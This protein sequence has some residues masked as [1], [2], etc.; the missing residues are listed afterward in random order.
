[1]KMGDFQQHKSRWDEE[2]KP[3]IK[4]IGFQARSPSLWGKAKVYVVDWLISAG[5]EIPD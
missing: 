3:D 1:M 2:A 4:K 5:Q